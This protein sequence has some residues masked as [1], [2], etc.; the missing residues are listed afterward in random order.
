M[1][2]HRKNI[3][4]WA[5][6]ETYAKRFNSFFLRGEEGLDFDVLNVFPPKFLLNS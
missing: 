1:N 3:N 2:E 6:N 5:A 4:S